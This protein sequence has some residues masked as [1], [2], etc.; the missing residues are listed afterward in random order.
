MLLPVEDGEYGKEQEDVP[1]LQEEVVGVESLEGAGGDD[2][3]HHQVEREPGDQE[4]S[5]PAP[6]SVT[7]KADN[8]NLTSCQTDILQLLTCCTLLKLL[9]I[10]Q[11]LRHKVSC[12]PSL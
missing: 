12:S 6:E 10:F 8:N 11:T 4:G 3:Q 5:P 7:G 9:Q 1:P 2:A